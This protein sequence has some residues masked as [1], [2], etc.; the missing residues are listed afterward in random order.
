[1][2]IKPFC[3]VRMTPMQNIGSAEFVRH[4]INRCAHDPTKKDDISCEL[5]VEF[6]VF[7]GCVVKRKVCVTLDKVGNHSLFVSIGSSRSSLSFKISGGTSDTIDHKRTFSKMV[8]NDRKNPLSR[9]SSVRYMS[10]R[11]PW[12]IGTEYLGMEPAGGDNTRWYVAFTTPCV[13]NS[14][15][16]LSKVISEPNLNEPGLPHISQS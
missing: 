9:I 14:R 2:R 12:N 3:D 11:V 7:L 16:V 1:M 13:T 8:C 4:D 6:V 15:A 5:A 10:K